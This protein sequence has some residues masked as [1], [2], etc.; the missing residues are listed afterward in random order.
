MLFITFINT[1][2]ADDIYICH[3]APNQ[4]PYRFGPLKLPVLVGMG[5]LRP[6]FASTKNFE[7]LT[8]S[9]KNIG[10]AVYLFK[11]SRNFR[12]IS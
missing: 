7:P 2:D 12:K 5:V 11:K 6:F 9:R 10:A 1:F 4:G 8:I 3:I